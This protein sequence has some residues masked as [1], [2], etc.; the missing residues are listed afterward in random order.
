MKLIENTSELISFCQELNRKP[1]IAVDLEFLREK[2]YYAKLCLIQV[3]APDTAAI[4]DPLVPGIE[5][6]AFFAVLHNPEVVKVF[7]SGRQDIEIIY[8]QA[9]FIPEPL[10]DT[11]TAAQV[12]GFGEAI[13]YENLV[14]T[15]LGIQLDKSCRLSDWSLRPLDAKQ[16]EYAL[17]DVTH[18]VPVYEHLRGKLAESGREHWLDEEFA[19]LADPETY[20]VH[21]EDVWQKIKHR[22]HNGRLLTVLR[23]LAAWRERRAQSKDTP[24]QSIIRD[25]CL[26]NIA[27]ACPD[28]RED[29]EKIRNIRKDV[30][31]GKLGEEIL[32]VIQKAVK[33][34]PSAYVKPEH[35]KMLPVGAAALYEL[36]RLLLKI[37]SQEQGVIPRLIA[38]D[39]DL[40]RLAVFS[41]RK[42]PVL[43]GWRF[44]IFGR[45]AVALREGKLSIS[46]D[47]ERHRI[48]IGEKAGN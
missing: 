27:A 8:H 15:I 11:Q 47:A 24:R 26:L 40:K 45:D 17:S 22:S 25:D 48:E 10:F 7:H 30:V 33:I 38:S 23:E 31:T 44:E 35:E 32:E 12:F 41:D 4:I 36:L 3:A 9:G 19:A 16:L 34:P 18:L 14:K 42:N 6:E 20:I 29:L 1:F 43:R 28:C 37:R 5:L 13:S 2:S 39:D 46:Y 21:P